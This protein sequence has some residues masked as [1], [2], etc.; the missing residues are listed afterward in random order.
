[1]AVVSHSEYLWLVA[2]QG[3]GGLFVLVHAW[4]GVDDRWYSLSPHYVDSK[5]PQWKQW[6]LR[7]KAAPTNQPLSDAFKERLEAL[8]RSDTPLYEQLACLLLCTSFPCHMPF[9]HM[10]DAEDAGHVLV[11]SLAAVLGLECKMSL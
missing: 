2:F 5:L 3:I 8:R 7:N 1:M 9:K 4:P 6:R 10:Q 11:T